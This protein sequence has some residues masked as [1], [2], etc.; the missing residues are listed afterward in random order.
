MNAVFDFFIR[1]TLLVNLLMLIGVFGGYFAVQTGGIQS[2]ADS[3]FGIFT[4]TTVRAG[5]SAEKMELGITVPLEE[6]IAEVDNVKKFISNSVEGLSL[7]QINAHSK[8]TPEQLSKL[9]ADL[10]KAIDR[11]AVRLPSDILEKPKLA[12][13]SSRDR[14]VFTFLVS[15]SA[16]EDTIRRVTKSL[17]AQLRE[18]PS[19]AG[20]DRSGYRD[21]EVRVMLDPE[22]MA[23]L[24]LGHQQISEA[25]Q[26]RNVAETGGS[27]ESFVGGQD[28]VAIGEFGHPKDVGSVIVRSGAKGDYLRLDDIADV[29]LGYEDSQ[30]QFY[31]NGLPAILVRL[32]AS[33]R[34]NEF[35]LRRQVMAVI[36]SMAPELPPNVSISVVDDGTELTASIMESLLNN[37]AIG[38]VLITAT[39]L[40]FFP[41][42][43]TLWVVAGL[44]IAICFG[45]ILMQFYGISI[46][47]IAMVAM[48]MMLGLLVD[49]AI[50]VSER[51]YFR[52]E[53]GNPPN[54]AA[55]RGLQDVSK[56]VFTGAL[57]TIIAML[58]LLLIGGIDAKFMWVI[59]AA[60]LFMVI[61][62]LF[63]CFFML[64]SHIAHSLR[65]ETGKTRA[66]WFREV[67]NRY[68]NWLNYYLRR[69]VLTGIFGLLILAAAL[70]VVFK[71]SIFE[72]HPDVDTN[73]V[74]VL[75]ELPTGSS[76]EDTR[77]ALEKVEHA[78]Y[79]GSRSEFIAHSYI[80]V[81]DKDAGRLDY[82]IEGQQQSWGKIV[83][84][85]RHF[86]DRKIS[87]FEIVQGFRESVE[88]AEGF[89][90]LSVQPIIDNPPSGSPVEL[91]V[92]HN[93]D[94]RD[95]V[96]EEILQFL[97]E[98][99]SVVE[100]W[101]NHSPGKG[102]IQL[103]LN[104]EKLAD[105]DLKVVDITRAL[106]LAYDGFIVDELQTHDEVIRYR[107][108][109]QDK[110]RKDV[111]ALNSLAVTNAS[112]AVI[113]LRN[114]ADFEVSQGKLSILHYGGMRTE[115]IYAEVD[116]YA[117]S[118]AEINAEIQ[119]FV[120]EQDY[121]KR[122]PGIRFR[123]GGELEAQAETAE[124][125]TSGLILVLLGIFVVMVTLFNSVSL[126]LVTLALVPISFIAVLFVFVIQGLIISMPAVIGLLSLIGVLVNGA[127]VMI[128][129]IRRR[130]YDINPDSQW[131]DKEVI[132]DGAVAR[133]RPLLIT[134]VTT[135]AGL[136]PAA[137]GLAGL[138][139]VTQALL[140][141]MFWG[142]AI[143]AVITLFSLPLFLE[144]NS[145]FKRRLIKLRERLATR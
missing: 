121:Y 95:L 115:T 105:Y 57:T 65:A 128:D 41:W 144:L 97:S 18:V 141:V 114:I 62:S 127:L 24:S 116:R 28:V 76:L 58:P 13:H 84:Q 79:N 145:R 47:A 125:M 43:A 4:V 132:I 48:I 66:N 20:V 21:Q 85:L 39:L 98:H 113:P 38:A 102:L 11:A 59:P 106:Q 69:P 103:N 112:G 55:L 60:V 133:L 77:R 25:I 34:V 83:I 61:G 30:N 87:A 45:V 126:P 51:I 93:G 91:Q 73:A 54:V 122:F 17:Q 46:S 29:V 81:G 32:K 118:P 64:P 104:H 27:L 135:L 99:P 8:A 111:N 35:R 101:S 109:Y 108:Q 31:L 136:G 3:D 14:S 9:E 139:P 100:H 138:H 119:Q 94:A 44:P 70:F 137:Y 52:Y 40:L 63:E 26:R 92:I 129:V 110:Y 33:E 56:P 142:V 53:Q 78:I 123:Y 74:M 15:G 82:L 42:R 6:E 12:S 5:A 23:K 140:L 86:N 107:L 37:A 131:L 117:I 22:K 1:R 10:Q 120:E 80:A 88:N 124:L 75:A 134:S 72:P 96:S 143:G 90:Y 36:E 2:A 67:E 16:S 49:D 7:I 130:Q 89:V 50:V 68:R 71:Y 19:V